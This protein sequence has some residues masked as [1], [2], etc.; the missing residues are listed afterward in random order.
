MEKDRVP[1]ALAVRVPAR[2]IE[3]HVGVMPGCG[4][5]EDLGVEVAAGHVGSPRAEPTATRAVKVG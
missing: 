5:A 4:D 3:D 2:G 1:E